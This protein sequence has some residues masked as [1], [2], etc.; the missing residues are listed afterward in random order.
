MGFRPLSETLLYDPSILDYPCELAP[1]VDFFSFGTN[2]LVSLM[3]GISRGDAYDKY[4]S[5][6]LKD[7]IILEDPFFVLPQH[8]IQKIKEFCLKAKA[9]N[10]NLTV[11]ICG[12]QAIYTDLS[13]LV[14]SGALDAVSIG[15]ENLPLLVKSLMHSGILEL[16]LYS[17][18]NINKKSVG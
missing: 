12:E 5:R 16:P 10:P 15:T 8:I 7:K 18:S 4:L 2:D 11:D 1:E 9:M 14:D 3:Y 6:Y 17:Y 13:S